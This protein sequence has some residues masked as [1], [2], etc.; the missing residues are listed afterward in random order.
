MLSGLSFE[1]SMPPRAVSPDRGDVACFV[2]YLARRRGVPLPASVRESLRAGGWIDGP[3]ARRAERLNSLWQLPV[4]IESWDVF[5]RLYAWDQRPLRLGE[6]ARCATYLG[7]SVRSFFA[8]GGRRAYVIRVADPWPYLEGDNR[9]L[10]RR[11][12]LA[13][14]VPAMAEPMRPFDPTDPGTWRG[15]EHLYG[16]ADV[17]HVCLPDLAD[18][19]S[20]EAPPPRVVNPLPLPPEVFTECSAEEPEPSPDT[21]LRFL[22]APRCDDQGYAAWRRAADT[23]RTFLAQH[24]RDTLFLGALPLPLTDARVP[25]AGGA[26]AQNDWLQ[27]LRDS[28]VLERRGANEAGNGTA[29]SAFTQLLWPWLH[30]TRSSD[31]PQ[32]LEPAEGL[33]AGRLAQNALTRGTFRSVAG[34]RLADVVATQPLLDLGCGFDSPSARLAERV[35]LIGSEPDGIAILS[36]VTSAPDRAWRPGGVSRL[37]SSLLRAARRVGEAQL[38]EANGELLWTRIRRSLEALLEDWR[39]AGALDG[40][41]AYSV[42]CGRDTMSQNDLDNGRV[43]VE[44]SVRPVAAVERVTVV[45]DLAG[46]AAR[47]ELRE[48]A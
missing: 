38:F 27:F 44:I 14:L 47:S 42:R 1:A 41:D 30:T 13:H 18:L 17:S 26:Y 20:R 19:C 3:W 10:R 22:S 8:N 43:R 37:M 34:S 12:R 46:G 4:A 29:A 23:V 21:G 39:R 16:V 28:S 40:K 31:L 36:D 48:V 35:C 9:V 5:D 32:Q 7:A 24:R 2:G 6:T 15:I 45:F 11:R 25:V 33:F